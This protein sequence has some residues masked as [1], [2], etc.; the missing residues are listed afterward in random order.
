MIR[1]DELDDAA[2]AAQD[3][4]FSLAYTGVGLTP[5]AGVS[6]LLPRVIGARRAM[7]LLLTNRSLSSRA[8]SSV[9]W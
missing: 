6:F 3:A 4:R 9:A 7:E 2:I 5:D 1:G 8:R